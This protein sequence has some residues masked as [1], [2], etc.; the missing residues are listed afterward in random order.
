VKYAYF[1]NKGESKTLWESTPHGHGPVNL[2][3]QF[4]NRALFEQHRAQPER[5]ISLCFKI[6]AGIV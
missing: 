1:I 2:E 6:L 3:F 5:N 4:Q